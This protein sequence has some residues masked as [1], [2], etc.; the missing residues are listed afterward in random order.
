MAK[1][2]VSIVIPHFN[3]AHLLEA[4]LES[5]RAQLATNWEVVVVL[6]QHFRAKSQRGGVR[7]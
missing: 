1:L 6:A 4:A 2:P 7:H 3:W 5:V